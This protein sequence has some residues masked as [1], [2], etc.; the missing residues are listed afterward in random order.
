MKCHP[1]PSSGPSAAAPERALRIACPTFL[2]KW[3][4]DCSNRQGGPPLLHLKVLTFP[5]PLSAHQCPSLLLS[6]F[7]KGQKVAEKENGDKRPGYSVCLQANH[8]SL[9]DLNL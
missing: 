8:I 6:S 4:E 3:Q 9:L 5:C 2:T 1:K 7:V